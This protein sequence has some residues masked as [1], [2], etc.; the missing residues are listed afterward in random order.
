M[1]FVDLPLARRI[2]A[3]EAESGRAC[4]ESMA[5]R[6]PGLGSSWI[7]AGGG[8]AAFSGKDSPISQG[9]GIGMAGPVSDEDLDRIETFYRERGAA[10]NLEVCPLAHA[11]LFEKLCR[12]G[13]RITE[14]SNVLCRT[15]ERGEAFDPVPREIYVR[16]ALPAEQTFWAETVARGFGDELPVTAQLVSILS[17]FGDRKGA[18]LWLAEVE[19]K[20]AGGAALAVVA[21]MAGLFGASTLPAFRR[22][23]VQQALFA[24]RL[25][26][27][28][29]QG[30]GLAYTIAVPGSVSHRNA[31]RAGFRVAYTRMKFILA[32]K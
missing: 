23:G 20:V 4:T 7:F 31:E 13:Y 14:V 21:E 17:A 10:T 2:E 27:A 22:R 24:A 8:C 11:S 15:I 5:A 25:A 3:F 1:Q 6:E 28:E 26:E 19:G 18:Q 30:A 32:G 16:R 9:V 29:R 12:R